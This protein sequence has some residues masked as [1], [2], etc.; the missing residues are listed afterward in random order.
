MLLYTHNHFIWATNPLEFSCHLWMVGS[1]FGVNMNEWIH[2]PCI[3]GSGRW[4]NDEQDTFLAHL[5]A[6]ERHLKAAVL[7][8]IDAD[9]S[10]PSEHRWTIFW[11]LMQ[12]VTELRSVSSLYSSGLHG[13]TQTHTMNVQLK[14][15]SNE[16]ISIATNIS[17]E[18]PNLLMDLIKWLSCTAGISKSF[19]PE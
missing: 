18:G 16:L 6:D 1:D 8:S 17:E 14:L 15:C 2:L 5:V 11:W 10:I 13:G 9:A 3:S 19:Y 12:H 7:L 4:C